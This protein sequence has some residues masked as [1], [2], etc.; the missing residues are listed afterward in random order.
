MYN[1][2]LQFNQSHVIRKLNELYVDKNIFDILQLNSIEMIRHFNI[3]SNIFLKWKHKGNKMIW[4]HTLVC[5]LI[6]NILLS[7]G[8]ENEGEESSISMSENPYLM[9]ENNMLTPIEIVDVMSKDS[10]VV[11]NEREEEKYEFSDRIKKR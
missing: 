10:V 7:P 6:L 8:K 11:G 2:I 1:K 3:D 9:I 5:T 4:L